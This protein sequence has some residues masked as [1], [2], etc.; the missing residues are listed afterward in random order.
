M[1]SISKFAPD[2]SSLIPALVELAPAADTVPVLLC[3]AAGVPVVC[4]DPPT[5]LPAN[6]SR[7]LN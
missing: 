1:I 7:V 3:E 5:P 6:T 4:G 2:N